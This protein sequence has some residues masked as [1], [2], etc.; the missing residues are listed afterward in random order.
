MDVG[1]NLDDAYANLEQQLDETESFGRAPCSAFQKGGNA[2]FNDCWEW[3][4]ERM[5][6]FLKNDEKCID[7]N[8]QSTQITG[9]INPQIF[10]PK[11]LI[12]NEGDLIRNIHFGGVECTYE[13]VYDREQQRY[14]F[15]FT[16]GECDMKAKAQFIDQEG[17]IV[18]KPGFENETNL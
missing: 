6:C 10:T 4:S 15:T 8:C 2:D 14:K 5:S 9:S 11:Q 16:L 13:M 17:K 12:G 3:D 18:F 1:P 7:V